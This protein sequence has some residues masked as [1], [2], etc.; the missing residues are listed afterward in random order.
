MIDLPVRQ[1]VTFKFLSNY[2]GSGV[3]SLVRISVEIASRLAFKFLPQFPFMFYYNV[4]S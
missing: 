1:Q 3:G 4:K 2:F